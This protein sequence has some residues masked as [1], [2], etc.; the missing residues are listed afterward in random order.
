MI[1]FFFKHDKLCSI[2]LI[3][4]YNLDS[5]SSSHTCRSMRIYRL[6][7]NALKMTLSFD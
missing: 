1:S 2:C 7:N 5:R 3:L 6:D 4:S